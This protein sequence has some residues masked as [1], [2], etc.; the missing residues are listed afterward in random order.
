MERYRGVP[1]YLETRAYVQKILQA[2]GK[3]VYPYDA[4]AASPSPHLPLMRPARWRLR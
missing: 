1:P 4:K 2:V 3:V